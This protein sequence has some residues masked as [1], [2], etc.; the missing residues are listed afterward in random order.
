MRGAGPQ[1]VAVRTDDVALADLQEQPRSRHQHC[2]ALGQA[3]QLGFRISMI[4]VHLVG[5]ECLTAIRAW[6]VPEIP[7]ESDCGCLARPHPLNLT[8]AISPVMGDVRL[9]LARALPH[10]PV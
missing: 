10:A 8:F 7:E 6:A 2:T 5:L 9:T 1:S 3:E 4:E